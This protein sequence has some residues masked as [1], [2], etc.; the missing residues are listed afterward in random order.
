MQHEIPAQRG[1]GHTSFNTA[2]GKAMH[3]TTN[4]KTLLPCEMSFN[5]A[6]GKAMHA[7]QWSPDMANELLPFQYRKR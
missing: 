2:S 3:A 4:T 1:L 6:S 5:T 7:T